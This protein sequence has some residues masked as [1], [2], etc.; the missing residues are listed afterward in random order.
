MMSG[1]TLLKIL[2]AFAW[3]LITSASIYSFI[4][5]LALSIIFA[6]I[7]LESIIAFLQAYIFIVLCSIYFND[8]I[9]L[10]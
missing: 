8:V 9:N 10:H 2:L 6:V 5:S 3:V 1:H 7:F 4:G